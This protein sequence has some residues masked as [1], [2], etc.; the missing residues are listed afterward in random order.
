M[1]FIEFFEYCKNNTYVTH[2]RRGQFAMNA[3]FILRKDIYDKLVKEDRD[4]IDPFYDDSL[5][6]A[7]WDFVVEN[8]RKDDA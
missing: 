5:M 8:W 4:K 6:P 1:T 3:L 7:F 2:E